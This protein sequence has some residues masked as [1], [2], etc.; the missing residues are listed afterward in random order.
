MKKQ[1]SHKKKSTIDAN[2]DISG[3]MN[4]STITAP[5]VDPRKAMNTTDN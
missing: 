1:Q 2:S 5:E 3:E 4:N